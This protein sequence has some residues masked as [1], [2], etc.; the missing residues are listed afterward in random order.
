M[1]TGFHVV[2]GAA[3]GCQ[4][5][6]P[7]ILFSPGWFQWMSLQMSTYQRE[8]LRT[9][10]PPVDSAEQLGAITYFFM[11]P[12]PMPRS[13]KEKHL[14]FRPFNLQEQKALNKCARRLKTVQSVKLTAN[15]VSQGGV[16]VV[17]HQLLGL[18]GWLV[19][20][21][22]GRLQDAPGNIWIMW[23]AAIWHW[24]K[25][26]SGIITER[27]KGLLLEYLHTKCICARGCSWFICCSFEMIDN[28]LHQ[29]NWNQSPSELR[30]LLPEALA[31]NTDSKSTW[32]PPADSWGAACG[33]EYPSWGKKLLS[34]LWNNRMCRS[35]LLEEAAASG[36]A[37]CH[38]AGPYLVWGSQSGTSEKPSYSR[39]LCGERSLV[40]E[41]LGNG[42]WTT[43]GVWHHRKQGGGGR[44]KRAFQG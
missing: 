40:W 18:T 39:G 10:R 14:S 5:V 38:V 17:W 33:A 42:H 31:P 28:S 27:K 8:K 19:G 3:L 26:V 11:E 1:E 16:K 13:E 25:N 30:L 41:V 4:L 12:F 43:E 20:A 29:P 24:C 6:P 37:V 32:S 15:K 21:S 7:V 44:E 2:V 34:L 36:P 23:G 35:R 22:L 9:H